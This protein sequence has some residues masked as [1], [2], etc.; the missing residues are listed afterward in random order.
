MTPNIENISKKSEYDNMCRMLARRET[1]STTKGI[2]LG[3]ILDYKFKKLNPS[4]HYCCTFY[5]SF[6]NDK[7]FHVT[8]MTK[9]LTTKVEFHVNTYKLINI[10]FSKTL[11]SS[12]DSLK[13]IYKDL[14]FE[15][16]RN[17]KLVESIIDYIKE[18]K[19]TVDKFKKQIG[20][21]E[22]TRTEARTKAQIEEMQ[23]NSKTSFCAETQKKP[24]NI[25]GILLRKIL[26]Q[27]HG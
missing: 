22:I 23:R 27:R 8:I 9:I 15:I 21:Q 12:N 20:T 19:V 18:I 13:N 10:S 14:T 4:H 6:F 17:K 1:N 7:I 5:N 25:Y 3:D 24:K 2:I 26:N 11:T 16:I